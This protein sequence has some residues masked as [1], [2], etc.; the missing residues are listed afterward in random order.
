MKAG[1]LPHLRH[2][3]RL[4][5]EKTPGML[6]FDDVATAG[7]NA[8]RMQARRARAE[9][10]V[11]RRRS[12]SSSPRAR[13]GI[14]KGAT[15]SHHN[16]LNNGYFVGEGLKLTPDDRLCIPVPL[17]HCFGMV[18]GNLGCLTHG[19]T[20]VYPAEAFDPLATLQA[21]AEERCTALYG[22]PTMFI[23]QLDHPEFAKFDLRSLRTGIMAGSPC[24]I[25]V[26][27]QVQ[28]QM[29]MR[30]VTIAYG[31]TETSPVSTQ[32][33]HRRSGRA[34]RLDGRPGAAASSR[35]RS[36]MPRARPCRAARPASSAPAATR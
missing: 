2:I 29:N 5:T 26:M 15:L 20:M 32:M 12:T 24:P 14:P 11:R 9:A 10:A 16:I 27:K 18:M 35:S 6:N 17:Y 30:E 4:G 1:K 22:V 21:V 25:E 23:A 28:S 7:G 3:V 33:R 36:S 8:E 34:A 13:P 31:M 19:A